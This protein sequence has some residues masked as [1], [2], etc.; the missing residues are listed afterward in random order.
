MGAIIYWTIIRTAI[1]IPALWLLLDLIDYKFWW[2]IAVM[3]VYGIIVH[4]A[5]IQ[6]KLFIERHREIIN[7][8]LCSSCCHFD[9]SA[10]LCMKHDKHP[11]LE[12]L[13]C[14]G[15]DWEPKR[16]SYAKNKTL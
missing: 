9:E 1:L 16:N 8:T 10:V 13:P 2:V 6:Y 14:E 12:E 15:I 11:T 4:P 7:D 3:A 5:V